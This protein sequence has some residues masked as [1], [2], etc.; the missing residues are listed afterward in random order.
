MGGVAAD[1]KKDKSKQA[2]TKYERMSNEMEA[3]KNK[4]LQQK[5]RN[6]SMTFPQHGIHL[7]NTLWEINKSKA[8]L[9]CLV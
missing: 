6:K 3:L 5:I 4:I 2:Q 8:A 9:K 7:N 1:K